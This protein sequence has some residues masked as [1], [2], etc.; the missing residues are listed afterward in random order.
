MKSSNVLKLI[1]Y[2]ASLMFSTLLFAPLLGVNPLIVAIVLFVGS[3][4][5]TIP[6]GSLAFT[7]F[8]SQLIRDVLQDFSKRDG[9]TGQQRF[10]MRTDEIGVMSTYYKM[11]EDTLTQLDLAAI[12]NLRSS[13]Q[14]LELFLYNKLA[15]SA[16][17]TRVRKGTGSSQVVSVV[18]TFF[19][20]IEEG[21]DM[22]FVN[23]AL[24]TFMNE[25]AS[26]E[27]A[28]N[29]AY[30]DHL[31]RT[32]P[33]KLRNI[34]T[35]AN[36]QYIVHLDANKWVLTGTADAGT[37]FTTFTGDAKN[38][39]ST[40]AATEIIQRVQIEAQQNNFL[41]L[42][43]PTI[44]A[45]P[46]FMNI[47]NE[48]IAR[49]VANEQNFQQF[50]S[51][52]DLVIDNGIIDAAGDQATFYIIAPGGLAGYSKTFPWEAHPAA[53]GGKISTGEDSW[54]RM[55][56][57]GEDTM[58]FTGVPQ[59]NVEVKEFMGFQDNS[60]TLPGNPDEGKIDIAQNL[61]FVV[62][63]GALKAFESTANKSPILKY[64]YKA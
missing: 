35:R 9:R 62:E 15:P 25:G 49:G 27:E 4:F 57:G 18:P 8:A 2:A 33:Q 53:E 21:I 54:S 29:L 7:S 51:W 26:K 56:I 31:S 58:I 64:I 45:S 38:I 28:I 36:A 34:Y 24:R 14:A 41:Q 23:H 12:E 47:L 10:E 16:G 63:F 5:V 55:T 46:T 42:G 13:Q 11:R 6:K 40:T 39:P 22:S 44:I 43:K 20:L 52:F 61:S 1:I 48:Y 17:A 30:K 50:I 59:I 32:L 19:N 60:A 37:E 3:L